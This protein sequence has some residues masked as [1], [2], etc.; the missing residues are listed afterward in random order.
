MEKITCKNKEDFFF[1]KLR[2]SKQ[3][4]NDRHPNLVG[5]LI[6]PCPLSIPHVI[7]KKGRKKKIKFNTKIKKIGK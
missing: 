1:N 6:L 5:I 3:Q 2:T 7:N 4:G